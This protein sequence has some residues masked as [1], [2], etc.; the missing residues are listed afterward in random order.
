[1]ALYPT[2][3]PVSVNQLAVIVICPHCGS[4][5]HQRMQHEGRDPI[6][7]GDTVL[8][9]SICTKDADSSHTLWGFTPN[10]FGYFI[11]FPTRKGTP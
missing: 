9:R 4:E 10:Q 3:K 5:E 1:V 2:I 11:K 6:R 7:P 8:F